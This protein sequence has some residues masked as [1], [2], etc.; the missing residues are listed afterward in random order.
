[1]LIATAANILMQTWAY[2]WTDLEEFA[3]GSKIVG[4]MINHEL[5][6]KSKMLILIF[7]IILMNIFVIEFE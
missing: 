7:H 1:M 4:F 3:P 2:M 6:S 5:S